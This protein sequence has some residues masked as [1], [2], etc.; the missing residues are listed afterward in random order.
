MQKRTPARGRQL[1]AVTIALSSVAIALAMFAYRRGR[2]APASVH[3][4]LQPVL[5]PESRPEEAEVAAE[6]LL[7][8]AELLG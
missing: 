7:L 4:P 1:V 6:E 3:R 5:R 2:E 8:A